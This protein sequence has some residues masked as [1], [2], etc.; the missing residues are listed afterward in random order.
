MGNPGTT[1]SP[2]PEERDAKN[3]K[4]RLSEA[5]SEKTV[6]DLEKSEEISDSSHQEFRDDRSVPSPDGVQNPEQGDGRAD[7]S[8]TGG[9]M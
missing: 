6:S 4:D 1:K 7:G 5:T 9:P 8:D 3:S 2:V